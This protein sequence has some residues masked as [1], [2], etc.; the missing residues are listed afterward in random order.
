MSEL[1]KAK[2]VQCQLISRVRVCDSCSQSNKSA[3]WIIEDERMLSPSPEQPPYSA[4]QTVGGFSCGCQP[5]ANMA[6]FDLA[7]DT[8]LLSMQ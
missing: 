4:S 7:K 2:A 3:D 8:I 5:V 1:I 6:D